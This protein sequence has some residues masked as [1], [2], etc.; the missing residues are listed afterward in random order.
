MSDFYGDDLAQVHAA[1]FEALAQA[2]ADTL[3]AELA[4]EPPGGR[5]LDLG[6]GAGPLSE[7]LARA[8]FEP[9][10]LD[11]SPALIDLARARS[12]HLTF[13]CGSVTDTLLPAAA[14]AVA[15]GEV[16]NYAT[17]DRPD[18]LARTFDRVF[19]SLKPGGV[20]LFDLAAPGRVGAGRGFTE[21]ADW[22]VGM[23]AVET[24]DI[25]ERRIATF[26]R[27]PD[28]AWTRADEV[29]RLRLWPEADVLALL[30]ATG[31]EAL[32]ISGYGE[33]PL[34]PALNVFLARRPA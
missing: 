33:L 13:T 14:A 1:A 2:A 5:V 31:F 25:L 21:T 23:T 4:G 30:R 28:G 12:P 27:R 15:A 20:F 19:A 16:L 22:A 29:H 18:A 9:W 11:I 17:A 6:C 8:G 7:R 34:P 10:G 32:R 24:G 3:L 26:R